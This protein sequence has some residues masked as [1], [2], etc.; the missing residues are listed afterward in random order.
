[1]PKPLPPPPVP[2]TDQAQQQ[3]DADLASLRRRGAMANIFSPTTTGAQL[4]APPLESTLR[5]TL[6]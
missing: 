2:T 5:R 4:G 1:M 6:G 3:A